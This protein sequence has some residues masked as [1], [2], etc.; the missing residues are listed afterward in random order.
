[1]RH[2]QLDIWGPADEAPGGREQWENLDPRGRAETV[3]MLALLIARAACPELVEDTPE[4]GDE[5]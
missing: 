5:Q 2:Q 3:Y 1:M 4:D